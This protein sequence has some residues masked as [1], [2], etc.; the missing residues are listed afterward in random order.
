MGLTKPM[1]HTGPCV[2][3]GGG[4]AVERNIWIAAPCEKVWQAVTQAEHLAQWFAPGCAWEIPLL[5]VGML[6]K[7]FNTATDILFATIEICH[8]PH[9]FALRWDGDPDTPDTILLTH[10]LMWEEYG[11][12]R[13][14]IYEA[15]YETLPKAIR[16]ERVDQTT[17]GYALSMENLRA[18]LTNFS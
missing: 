10:F 18:Y 9:H 16:Q 4:L 17:Q 8:P 3:M 1:E 12:T 5:E 7:F 6:V 11:G 2:R 15:G 14:M 13:V